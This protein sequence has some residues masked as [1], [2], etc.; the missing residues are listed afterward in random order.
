MEPAAGDVIN[1]AGTE[2]GVGN[3]TDYAGTEPGAGDKPTVRVRVF[4]RGACLTM[5]VRSM[6]RGT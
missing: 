3:V 2:P 4:E 1:D 5:W 6:D